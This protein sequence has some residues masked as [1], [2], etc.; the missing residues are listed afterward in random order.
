M[1]NYE[2]QT[3]NTIP[4]GITHSPS[5]F[6]M[7]SVLEDASRR[8]Q[9]RQN[10]SEDDTKLEAMMGVLLI[11]FIVYVILRCCMQNWICYQCE[12]TRV[13]ATL[14]PQFNFVTSS[15][16]S[17][18]SMGK[19]SPPPHYEDPPPYHVAVEMES[20]NKTEEIKVLCSMDL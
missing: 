10:T 3:K 2:Y 20:M 12:V 4:P 13:G 11:L 6:K 1:D 7:T 15:T 14:L 16:G 18:P 5:V 8:I 9:Q 17:L 19:W